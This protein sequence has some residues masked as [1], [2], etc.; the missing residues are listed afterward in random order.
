[1]G[2]C[3]ANSPQIEDWIALARTDGIGPRLFARLM[4]RF[5]SPA[6]ALR[7][8]AADLASVEGIGKDTAERIVA[9]RGRFDVQ[10]EL[11]LASRHGVWLVHIQDPRYPSTLKAIYDPPPLLY[12]KGQLLP[13]H[14]LAVAIVGSR[15]CSLYGQEQ[16]SRLAYQLAGAGFTIVSGMARGIDT[17]AHQGALS[18]GGQTIAVQGCGLARVFPPENARL[19]ELI[20]NSGACVSELP[21]QYEPLPENFPARNR[22]IAGLGIATVVVEAGL[23]S[24]ALITARSALDAGREVMAVPG[25]VDSPLSKGPHQLIKQG[26]VLVESAEDVLEALGQIGDCLKGSLAMVADPDDDQAK[27]CP[28]LEGHQKAVYE[29]LGGEP[30]HPDQIAAQTGLAPGQVAAALVY[31][32]VKG[33]AKGIEGNLFVRRGPVLPL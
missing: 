15:H 20:C 17:A 26:A 25:R 14:Q 29:C 24:G 33:L 10:A 21:M 18:V 11:D 2:T 6:Q 9:S 1:M 28:P 3:P 4:E 27:A 19:F 7:A 32:Q 23:R 13:S 22:I 30:L 12:V 31:L 5:G 8:T 16:A